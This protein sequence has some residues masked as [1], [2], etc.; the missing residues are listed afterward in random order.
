MASALI[1]HALHAFAA[2]GLTHAMIGVDSENP[3]G[4]ARLYR[5]LGF[6][7]ESRRINHQIRFQ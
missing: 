5:S 2:D 4:A 6:R 7:P 1:A 3:T